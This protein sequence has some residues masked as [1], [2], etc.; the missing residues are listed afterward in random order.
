MMNDTVREELETKIVR[1]PAGFVEKTELPKFEPIKP[2]TPQPVKQVPVNVSA[3][4]LSEP[5]KFPRPEPPIV[6][7]PIATKFVS[8]P[9]NEVDETV[10]QKVVTNKL[11]RETNPTLVGFQ[12]ANPAVPDWRL[13]LQNSI[14]KRNTE[15]R[16]SAPQETPIAFAVAEQKTP[17]ITPALTTPAPPVVQNEKLANAIKR[18]EASKKA[19]GSG[20]AVG[21][22]AAAQARAKKLALP[23]R[24]FP[25]DIVEKKPAPHATVLPKPAVP[26][27]ELPKPKLVEPVRL[28][29]QKFDTN[30]LPPIPEPEI[31]LPVEAAEIE[32]VESPT[33]TRTKISFDR[34]RIWTTSESERVPETETD[35]DEEIDDLAP[36]SMR[37]GA[38]VFDLIIGGFAAGIV[39]SPFLITNTL[40]LTSGGILAALGTA[41]FVMFLYFTGTIA[42]MGRT[43]GMRLFAIEM[44][45]AEENELPTMHQAAVHSA[46]YL[47]SLMLFGLGFLPALFNEE[48]RT[49]PDLVSGTLLIREY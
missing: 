16:P 44:I 8:E 15:A 11:R 24:A 12:P 32:A 39:L 31:P 40:S 21:M 3:P 45:D 33:E 28:E 20:A 1:P 49:M 17:S 34:L 19:F 27:V 46:V 41:M 26:S 4:T 35:L 43:F 6:A 25:F 10:K 5:P 48:R 37:F 7:Q 14:R 42:F 29:K 22:A 47:I 2:W 13:Q 36:F 23:A 9:V 30:K 38:A 18:I